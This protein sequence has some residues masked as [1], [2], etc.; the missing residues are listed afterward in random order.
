MDNFMNGIEIFWDFSIFL[1]RDL[2]D[3]SLFYFL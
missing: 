1:G 3:L 2:K